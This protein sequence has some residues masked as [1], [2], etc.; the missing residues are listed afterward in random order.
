LGGEEAAGKKPHCN[1]IVKAYIGSEEGSHVIEGGVRLCFSIG[2]RA[3]K[4][5]KGQGKKKKKE[6]NRR[7]PSS[8]VAGYCKSGAVN[9]SKI[10]WAKEENVG[11]RVRSPRRTDWSRCTGGRTKIRVGRR[12]FKQGGTILQH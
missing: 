10:G 1:C 8:S 4:V 3:E 11:W 12:K 2:L 7:G 6:L 9:I 5:E